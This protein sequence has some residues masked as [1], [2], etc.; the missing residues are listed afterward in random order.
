M[1]VTKFMKLGPSISRRN[2]PSATRGMVRFGPLCREKPFKKRVATLE[3]KA[4]SESWCWKI[5]NIEWSDPHGRVFKTWF[6]LLYRLRLSMMCRLPLEGIKCPFQVQFCVAAVTHLENLEL[7][8]RTSRSRHVQVDKMLS[9]FES[10]QNSQ[11]SRESPASKTTSNK[12]SDAFCSIRK[13]I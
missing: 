9:C 3:P 6:L 7:G 11:M 1:D 10:S 12:K 5:P 4:A 8:C 13:K 2:K